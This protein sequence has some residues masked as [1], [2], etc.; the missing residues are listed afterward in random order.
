MVQESRSRAHVASAAGA[1]RGC[2][3]PGRDRP[4]HRREIQ[5]AR[6]H[7]DAR[8]PGA[9][10]RANGWSRPASHYHGRQILELPPPSQAWAA[11][12]IL[13][14]LAACVPRGRRA[15]LSPPSGRRMRRVLAP[16]RRGEEARVR[17][18][19][20]LQRRPRLRRRAARQAAVRVLRGVAVRPGRSAS[21]AS[22]PGPTERRQAAG[23]HRRAVDRRQRG[24]HGVLGQQQFLRVRLGHHRA[25]LRVRAAQSRRPV[26]ARSAQPQRSSHPTSGRST[27]CPPGSCCT[28]MA[29]RR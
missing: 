22:T 16:A 2:V 28:R 12:E 19:A 11:E 26:H 29:R 14:I 25:G 10:I 8:G 17:R 9:P 6:R 3:L 23:R 13:N 1:G 5:G 24:Q 7:H 4:G 20:A 27:P 18:S 21:R 15:R